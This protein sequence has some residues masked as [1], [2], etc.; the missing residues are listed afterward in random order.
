MKQ[1]K[2]KISSYTLQFKHLRSVPFLFIYLFN[3]IFILFIYF[4]SQ[5]FNTF[6]QQGCIKL[7][8]SDNKDMYN[9][10]KDF[11]FR[12][13]L[14]FWTFY[15][16]KKSYHGFKKILS[17]KFLEQEGKKTYRPQTFER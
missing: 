8:K 12:Q 14:F 6:V 17:S 3:L 5:E 16:E 1:D 11:Y 9:V 13:M 2:L 7:I 4:I 15:S 10:A